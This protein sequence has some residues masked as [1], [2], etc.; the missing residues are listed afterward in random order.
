MSKAAKRERRETAKALRDNH[1]ELQVAERAQHAWDSGWNTAMDAIM[2]ALET[3]RSTTERRAVKL[4]PIELHDITGLRTRLRATRTWPGHCWLPATLVIPGL[5]ADITATDVRHMAGDLIATP[6]QQLLGLAAWRSAPLVVRFDDDIAQALIDTPLHGEIPVDLLRR[7]PAPSLYIDMPWLGDG[8]GSYVSMDSSHQ[9][10][11]VG[12]E[13]QDELV[14]ATIDSTGAWMLNY[15]RL[16]QTTIVA[17]LAASR[18]DIAATTMSVADQDHANVASIERF[19][20]NLTQLLSEIASLLL[21]L[22]SDEP[23]TNRKPLDR[24][25]TPRSTIATAAIPMT[26]LDVGARLGAALR[27]TTTAIPP[28]D[29]TGDEPETTEHLGRHPVPHMRR[30]HWHTYWTG[31]RTNPELRVAKLRWVHMIQV[32]SNIPVTIRTAN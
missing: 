23:D 8:C 24:T 10:G 29:G 4:K 1:D 27:T 28:T 2:H 7:L 5:V 19:G 12:V 21:Y 3:G 9:N 32:G 31:P 14:I 11:G 20:R 22:C 16:D 13:D 15:L 17:S 25:I 30:A 18:A 6:T 26:V